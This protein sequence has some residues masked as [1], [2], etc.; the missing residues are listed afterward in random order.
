M[1]KIL[2]DSHVLIWWFAGDDRLKEKHIEL[3]EDTSNLIFV[4]NA[5]LFEIYIKVG[6]NKLVLPENFMDKLEAVDISILSLELKH[7]YHLTQLPFHHKDPFD[8][9]IIATAQ[10]EK[11]SLMSYDK[12][13]R[14]YKVDII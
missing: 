1:N 7:F 10:S 6:L 4:S 2:I 11:L 13:L 3:L 12:I 5:S 8:R 9:M 14:K